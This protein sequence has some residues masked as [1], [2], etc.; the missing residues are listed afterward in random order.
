MERIKPPERLTLQ[1]LQ[2]PGQLIANGPR[3]EQLTKSRWTDLQRLC[4]CLLQALQV[5]TSRNLRF[6][7]EAEKQF[8]IGSSRCSDVVRGDGHE[9]KFANMQRRKNNYLRSVDRS[10]KNLYSSTHRTS[11]QVVL[12]TRYLKYKSSTFVM[13]TLAT[14][15]KRLALRCAG[16]VVR[17]GASH[18]ESYRS[19]APSQTT[20]GL[21][22]GVLVSM[23]K[24]W[25]GSEDSYSGR[26]RS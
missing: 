21:S 19:P 2:L 13:R 12:L 15:F 14:T 4:K 8:E 9:R 17:A 20:N 11:R 7:I 24:Q 25:F 18:I 3:R 10:V 22:N 16:G 26:G 5:S 6:N 23:P 1:C